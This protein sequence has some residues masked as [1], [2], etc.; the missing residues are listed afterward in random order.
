MSYVEPH[1]EQ[2]HFTVC[3]SSSREVYLYIELLRAPSVTHSIV[4]FGWN[5][6]RGIQ[7]DQLRSVLLRPVCRS[8][9]KSILIQLHGDSFEEG[10]VCT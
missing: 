7:S 4:S 1:W 3:Y 8:T 10:Q 9:Y 5:F 2:A 6:L